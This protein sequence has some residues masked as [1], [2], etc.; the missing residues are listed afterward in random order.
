MV[1]LFKDLIIKFFLLQKQ[2]HRKFLTLKIIKIILAQ[3]FTQSLEYLQEQLEK[4]ETVLALE[5][6]PMEDLIPQ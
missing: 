5:S 2:S 6:G 1:L 4:L 3:G